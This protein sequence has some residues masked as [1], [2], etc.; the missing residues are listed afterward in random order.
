MPA[1][2]AEC[3]D[4]NATVEQNLGLV[5]ACAHRF[6][7]RGIEYD[8]LFQ[9]GCIG[10]VK[11]TD[12]FDPDRGVMFSTYAVPVI[13][14]EIRRL[15]RDG[16]TVKVSRSIKELGLKTARVREQLSTALGR[17]PTVGEVARAMDRPPEEIAEA[18][19]AAA[20]PVSLTGDDEEGG[21]QMDLPVD[22]PEELLSD[23][24]SLKQVLSSLEER[25]RRLIILRYYQSRTQTE[26]AAVLG[27]TQVQVSRREKK[28]LQHFR[29][30]M[31][32]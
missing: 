7:G 9:A 12:A 25:D 28:I 2:A 5:H 14:G 11:A 6:K 23:L 17:E 24:L 16:G 29:H 21:G 15:F 30:Q 19:A 18:L 3:L 32:E 31:L 4:R 1:N 22:S 8:D 10:L 20:P 27:M 26:T 13:L